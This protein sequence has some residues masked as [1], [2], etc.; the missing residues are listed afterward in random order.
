MVAIDGAPKLAPFNPS[1]VEVR[2]RA[3]ELARVTAD[4]VFFDLGCG[5]GLMLVH[6]VETSGCRA[7]GIEYDDVFVK[8][9]QSLV[10]DKGFAD[11]VEVR[12]Q[13]VCQVADLAQAT[14]IFMFLTIPKNDELNKKVHAAYE[15]GARIVSNMFSLPYLGEPTQVAICNDVCKLYF[16]E[17]QQ[18]DAGEGTDTD[19]DAKEPSSL[20]QRIPASSAEGKGKEEASAATGENDEPQGEASE[21]PEK[22]DFVKELERLMDPL[23]NPLLMKLF[24]YAMIGLVI[25]I[26]IMLYLGWGNIHIYFLSFLTLG[27][28]VSLNSFFIQVQAAHQREQQR[29]ALEENSLSENKEQQGNLAGTKPSSAENLKSK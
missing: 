18:L 9:A 27:L 6:A 12:H 10:H 26:G 22:S 24:N 16:Y 15:R 2:E 11:K 1:S 28:A 23:R 19:E 13:D 8:R 21:Q 5:D 3:C 20:R 14:V 4:D 29:K 17:N 7:V 25:L